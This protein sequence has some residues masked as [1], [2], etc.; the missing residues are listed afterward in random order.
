M[1]YKVLYMAVLKF[2]A[3]VPFRGCI[4]V[5]QASRSLSAILELPVCTSHYLLAYWN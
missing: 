5:T 3:S 2:R 1:Y 4:V